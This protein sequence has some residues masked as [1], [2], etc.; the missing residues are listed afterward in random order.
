[1][2]TKKYRHKGEPN[3]CMVPGFYVHV[4][5]KRREKSLHLL[6]ISQS[7]RSFEMLADRGFFVQPLISY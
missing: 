2:L 1:L 4:I 3:K 6:E 7:L 5:F